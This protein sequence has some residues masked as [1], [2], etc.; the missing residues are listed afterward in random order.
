MD[1]H[2]NSA[3]D[4]IIN[5]PCPVSSKHPRM[6]I[7]DR[8]AQFSPFAALVGYE[9]AITETGRVT[10]DKH[11]LS[12][13]AKTVLDEKLRII[14]NL[15]EDL[16]ILEITYFVADKRKNGGSYV[17]VIGHIKRIDEYRRK[18]IM[19][20]KTVIPIDDIFEIEGDALNRFYKNGF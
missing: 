10:D 14:M 1:K 11:E 19:E 16:P 6:P 2:E 7:G 18:V 9:D 12:E 13:E 15:T 20:D 8:A 17:T 5:L 3:Y 4:D